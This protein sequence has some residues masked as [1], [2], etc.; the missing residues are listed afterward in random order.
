[1]SQGRL[2]R[3]SAY[4]SPDGH[5]GNVDRPKGMEWLSLGLGLAG[6]AT[7]AFAYA[8]P[9]LG[10]PAGT[11]QYLLIQGGLQPLTGLAWFV[12]WPQVRWPDKHGSAGSRL[13]TFASVF[14]L[15][16]LAWWVRADYRLGALALIPPAL[17]LTMLGINWQPRSD[18]WA[19]WLWRVFY[20]FPAFV[21]ILCVLW[22]VMP[23]PKPVSEVRQI[24]AGDLGGGL[25]GVLRWIGHHVLH[26]QM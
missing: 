1:M 6:A 26:L 19:V 20:L 8:I 2:Q 22:L 14:V 15:L 4:A 7:I 24:M 13:I 25:K 5:D 9:V 10:P 18:R 3:G 21:S 17:M 11:M 12:A 23:W 16:Q